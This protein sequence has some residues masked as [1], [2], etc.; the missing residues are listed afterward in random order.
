M[1]ETGVVFQMNELELLADA[2]ARGRHY[3]EADDRRRGLIFTT[4][5]HRNFLERS[6]PGAPARWRCALV[7]LPSMP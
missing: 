5:S 1:D 3:I 6:T 2:E 7:L 4:A